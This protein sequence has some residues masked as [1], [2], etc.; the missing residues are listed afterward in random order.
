MR[1]GTMVKVRA[2]VR[3]RVRVMTKAPFHQRE[4]TLT[5]GFLRILTS[6]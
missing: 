2:R 5:V 4:L 6:S 3:V 1:N